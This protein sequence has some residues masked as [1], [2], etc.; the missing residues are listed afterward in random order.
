MTKSYAQNQGQSHVR[1]RLLRLSAR[2]QLCVVP[3]FV[4][5]KNIV[6]SVAKKFIYVSKNLTSRIG[7]CGLRLC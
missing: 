3:F 5:Q 2:R 6:P 4:V 7:R 1:T